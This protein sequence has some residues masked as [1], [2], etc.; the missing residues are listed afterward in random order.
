[1]AAEKG[2][3][4]Q[5]EAGSDDEADQLDANDSISRISQ[6]HQPVGSFN[7]FLLTLCS[8]CIF[9]SGLVKVSC[10]T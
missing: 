2:I 8:L 1:M 10:A 4:L 3:A 7:P 5:W 9:P 6:Q